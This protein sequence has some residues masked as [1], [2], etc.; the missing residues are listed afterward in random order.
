[1]LPV[2][3][4][5]ELAQRSPGTAGELLSEVDRGNQSSRS[6]DVREERSVVAGAGADL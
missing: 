6:N 2:N 4:N 5:L 1:M 3:S